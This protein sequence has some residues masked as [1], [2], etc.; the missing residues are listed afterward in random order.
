MNL[1]ERLPAL[2]SRD[3]RLWFAGQGISVIGTWLQNTGQAWLVLKLTN[4]PLKLGILTSVQ[5]LPS[6]LLS[7]FI[8]PIIDRFP[9]RSILLW[10]QSLFALL[11][12]LLA[13][14]VFSGQERYWHVLAIAA[15]T[16]L[17]TAVD[18]PARQS[19]V[20]EQV[21]DRDAVVN[22]IA[23]NSTI[24]NIARVL[25]PAISGALI[26]VVGIPWTFA[27]NAVSYL[28]VIAGLWA[29][30]SG[31]VAY[32]PGSGH[33]RGDIREG[34]L[35]IRKRKSIAVLLIIVGFIS[36]FLLNFNILIPSY[37]RLT[38]RLGAERYGLLMSAMGV[39]S[40]L[41]GILMSLGG[42]SLQPKPA[43]IFGAGFVLSIG[44]ILIGLQHNFIIS[45]VLLA[46][47]GFGMSAFATMCNTSVQIQSSPAMRGRVMAAYNLVFV[48][49]T[50]IGSLYT[51]QLS[52]ALGSSAGF[53]V[54][55]MI[56]LVFLLYMRLFV[57]P[58]VFG[59][60]A[61]FAQLK[62]ADEMK[63]E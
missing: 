41:A 56:G 7:L 14:I 10:T 48:G 53:L 36:T 35:Y 60:I 20:S 22:A 61:A 1:R 23:L 57:A 3:Y 44:M 52:D 40:M 18:W 59:S 30:R 26:A 2:A 58:K 43:Y 33:W 51:G 47:C 27:L 32:A 62:D 28:A 46:A 9:K 55:G 29:M 12:A 54:S 39:G 25:G 49:S 38:L 11:A 5:Y 31:R 45:A 6:L 16:G 34:L 4:S 19:F 17:V 15:C 8:G 50:P 63:D 37:A 13:G 24:F 42:R 21:E